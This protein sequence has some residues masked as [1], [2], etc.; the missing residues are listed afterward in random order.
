MPK[1]SSAKINQLQL[2]GQQHQLAVDPIPLDVTGEFTLEGT[3][4]PA[5]QAAAYSF[6]MTKGP[7]SLGF[8]PDAFNK[9]SLYAIADFPNDRV[10]I[11]TGVPITS[12]G[13]KTV[14]VAF[15]W[16]PKGYQAFL[17]G[18]KDL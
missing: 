9:Q 12:F 13:G 5:S 1:D 18:K 7:T 10:F 16:S 2:S 3:F 14:R 17:D 11:N 4:T 15:T 6:F 8:S